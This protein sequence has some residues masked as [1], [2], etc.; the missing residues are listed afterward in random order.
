MRLE[1][2]VT[3][4]SRRVAAGDGAFQEFL[5]GSPPRPRSWTCGK[6]GVW[7]CRHPGSTRGPDPAWSEA[8]TVMST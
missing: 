2:S 1:Q 6:L 8:G 5:L 7:S 3:R 4:G